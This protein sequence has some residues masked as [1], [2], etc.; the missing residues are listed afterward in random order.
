MFLIDE[1]GAT[2]RP[3]LVSLLHHGLALVSSLIFPPP[4]CQSSFHPYLPFTANDILG[5]NIADD[6]EGDVSHKRLNEGAIPRKSTYNAA[7][8]AN[9]SSLSY[10]RVS[11]VTQAQPCFLSSRLFSE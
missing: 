11:I 8:H 10:Q 4:L 1:L 7:S 3:L 2:D 5:Q 6:S 9:N